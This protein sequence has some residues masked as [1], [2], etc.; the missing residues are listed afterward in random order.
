MRKKILLFSGLIP[1]LG[2][3]SKPVGAMLMLYSIFIFLSFYGSKKW[4]SFASQGGT[5]KAII[6]TGLLVLF[7]TE[8][9]AWLNNYFEGFK[10]TGALFSVNYFEDLLIGSGFYIGI[11][12]VWLILNRHFFFSQAQAF[13]MY[14][15][16]GVFLEQNGAVFRLA[17]QTAPSNFAFALI[18]ILFVFL[19]HGSILGLIH[20]RLAPRLTGSR[21]TVWKYPLAIVAIWVG[22]FFGTALSTLL[23]R[24]IL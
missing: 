20:L 7:F 11:T 2:I 14:G 9:L 18:M 17:A 4:Q 10:N 13:T 16:F 12:A 1:L 3:F 15:L 19:I 6:T 21:Q 23:S 24:A 22:V 5:S 8:T